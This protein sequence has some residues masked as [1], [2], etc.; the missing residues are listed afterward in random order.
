MTRI[1]TIKKIMMGLVAAVIT[2]S[3]AWAAPEAPWKFGVMADTQWTGVAADPANNPNDVAV[4]IINQLNPQFIAAGVKF[5]VQVGD[6]TESGQPAD[7][8]VRAAAAQPLY[9]AGIG[10]FPLRGNHETS[11]PGALAFTNNF[12]QTQGLGTNCANYQIMSV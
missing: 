11:Q 10:F 9:N 5:V 7:L 12:P 3:F 8:A 2:A 1:R 6:L 4:S